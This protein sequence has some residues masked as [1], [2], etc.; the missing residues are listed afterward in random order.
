M[1][2]IRID[3]DELAIALSDHDS[4]WVLDMQTGKLFMREWADLPEFR[5]D[6]GLPVK[7]PEEYDD[8]LEDEPYGDGD[9]LD[10]DRFVGIDHM[11]SHEGFRWMEDFANSQADERVRERLLDALDRPKPFRRFKDALPAFPQVRD[12]WFRY[13]EEKLRDEARAWVESRGID[14]ELFVLGPAPAE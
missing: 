13:E 7:D 2:R 12:A 5:E 8:D 14:A 4:E 6:M 9:V 10:D 11:G 1:S 3:I